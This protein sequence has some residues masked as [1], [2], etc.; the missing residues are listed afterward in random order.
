VLAPAVL[1]TITTTHTKTFYC[2]LSIKAFTRHA[3]AKASTD[4]KSFITETPGNTLLNV[5][6]GHGTSL[7]TI[8]H[9]LLC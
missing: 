4:S 6:E 5:G 9:G 2:A 8:C 7:K 3:E 1:F